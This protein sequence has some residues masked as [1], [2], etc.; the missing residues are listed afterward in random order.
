MHSD[1]DGAFGL[2]LNRPTGRRLKDFMG[3]KDLGMLAMAPVFWGGPVGS[4]QILLAAFRWEESAGVWNWRHDITIESAAELLEDEDTILRVFVGYTG[5]S[6]G[7]LE[8]ELKANTWVVH[9]PQASMLDPDAVGTAPWV[10]WIRTHGPVFEFLTRIPD[11]L[12]KN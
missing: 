8:S 6:R 10:T 4:E 11:N 7:Q 12:G 1:E 5:W 2:V 9:R 3:N